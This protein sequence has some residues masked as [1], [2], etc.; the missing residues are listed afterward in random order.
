MSTEPNTFGTNEFIDWCRLANIEPMLAVN[1]G[2][3]DGDAARNL[4][5][6]CNHPQGT[7]LSD[8]RRRHGWTEPHGVSSGAWATRWTAPGRWR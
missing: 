8:L 1:L 4:L 3:R 7:A 2:T 5:E 6:Y